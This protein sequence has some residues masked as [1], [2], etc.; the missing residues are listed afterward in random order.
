MG[1]LNGEVHSYYRKGKTELVMRLQKIGPD[2]FT[3]WVHEDPLGQH[4]GWLGWAGKSF[5]L[6]GHAQA[7]KHKSSI[8]VDANG[9]PSRKEHE[10]WKKMMQTDP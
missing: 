1:H 10:A 4:G 5:G 8:A 3:E 6:D 9:V 7:Q 2:K